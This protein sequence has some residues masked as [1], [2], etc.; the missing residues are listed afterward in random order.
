MIRTT[1]KRYNSRLRDFAST[2][3]SEN[4][5]SPSAFP[6][7][8]AWYDASA[9]TGLAD[10]DPVATWN[11]SSAGGH[12]GTSAGTKRPLYKTGILAGHPVVRF[13]ATASITSGGRV[14]AKNAFLKS[15]DLLYNSS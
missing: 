7:L 11:D 1:E 8:V 13:D 10:S 12:N 2:F 6:N 4:T 5:L 9:I 15:A 3:T 14:P